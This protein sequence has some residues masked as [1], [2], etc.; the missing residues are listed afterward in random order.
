[1]SI[2]KSIFEHKA[3]EVQE[4]K[5]KIPLQEIKAMAADAEPTRGFR[6]ALLQTRN[7]HLNHKS[8]SKPTPLPSV[9][10]RVHE[11]EGKQGGTTANWRRSRHP[12]EGKWSEAESGRERGRVRNCKSP[13]NLALIAEI[14]KASPSKGLIRPDFDPVGVAQAYER[15]GAHA[16]SVLTDE[17][18]FQ[19]SP[20][21]LRLAKQHTSLPCLRKD[22]VNDPYQVYQARAWGADAVLLIVAALS[23]TQIEELHGLIQSLGM[24]VLVEV[25]TEEECEVA[26]RIKCPLIGVNNRNLSNFETTLT[27]SEQLLP[28]IHASGAVAVSE[29]AL[30][31]RSD[32]DRVQAAGANAVL[33]GTTFC[34]APNIESKVREVMG[35]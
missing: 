14:K 23:P 15:A 10:E 9:G 5:A 24:D 13:S 17:G 35:W 26:L 1:M 30:E 27:I 31:T 11:V 21:N 29:S 22:F 8:Y 34:A 3:H 18:Y 20:E 16:L 7:D 12:A 2:L 32:L 6:N 28:A 19:G 4:A 25:H 33:I